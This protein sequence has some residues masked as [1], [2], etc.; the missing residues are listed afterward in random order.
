MEQPYEIPGAR[1]CVLRY[2]DETKILGNIPGFKLLGLWIAW[3]ADSPPGENY[4]IH[5]L[6]H[7][8]SRASRFDGVKPKNVW[9]LDEPE[10]AKGRSLDD[11]PED[12]A[13]I[14]FEVTFMVLTDAQLDE[15]AEAQETGLIP[16]RY[17]KSESSWKAECK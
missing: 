10:E 4:H 3:L 16:K 13:S 12:A 6:W 15:L 14:P 5:L 1:V 17:W 8:E 11:V 9:F 7:L 2:Y